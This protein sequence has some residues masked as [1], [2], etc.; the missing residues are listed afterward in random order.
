M[1]RPA[2]LGSGTKLSAPGSVLSR[3]ALPPAHSLARWR[4]KRPQP[5][6]L[7]GRLLWLAA[8]FVAVL[9][10]DLL[11]LGLRSGPQAQLDI[12]VWGDQEHFAPNSFHQQEEGEGGSVTYRWTRKEATIR[13]RG[14][15]PLPVAWLTLVIGGLP[16]GAETP[17]VAELS[18]EGTGVLAVPVAAARRRYHVLAPAGT[19]DDGDFDLRLRSS[20]SHVSPDPRDVGIRFDDLVLAWP[21]TLPLLPHWRTLLAQ[22]L[23]AVVAAAIAWRLGLPRVGLGV[24]VAGLIVVLA[25]MAAYNLFVAE[26]WLF[27]SVLCS[28]LLLGLTSIAPRAIMRIVPGLTIGQARGLTGVVVLALAVR[29]WGVSYPPFGS[30]DLYI[31]DPRLV[32]VQSGTL[33]LYDKPTEFAHGVT[34]VPP[35]FYMLALPLKLLLVQAGLALHTLYVVFDGLHV[36]FVTLLVVRLGGSTRAATIAGSLLALLPIQFTALWWGFGPQIAGQSLATALAVVAAQGRTAGRADWIAAGLLF[37]FI[38][39]THPG[40]ALLTGMTLAGYLAILLLHHHEPHLWRRWAVVLGVAGLAAALLL[41]GDAIWLY[42]TGFRQGRAAVASYD[43]RER[44]IELAKGLRSSVR[45][46]SVLA[47]LGLGGLLYWTNGIRRWTVLAWI[48]GSGVFLLVDL[49]W[50]LQVRYGYFIMPMICAGLGLLLDRLV[51]RT[52][53]GWLGVGGI[54]GI[55]AYSGLSLWAS[56]VLQ[57]VKPAMSALTH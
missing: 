15:T 39:L 12:G 21:T 56:G 57:A 16:Q 41:Y 35:A 2:L 24:A 3:A 17:R 22:W 42:I 6:P 33:Y 27:R 32:R 23:T 5:R 43:N 8:I 18:L 40:V 25:W 53:L 10:A 37:C 20:T 4:V 36:L 30:Y 14:F 13:V 50:G 26:S 46:L 55:T 52:R 49:L 1:L 38:L 48:G 54:V 44:L 11:A 31:H 47:L 28:L 7:L 51:A 45:P 29:L 34:L 19:L 9:G